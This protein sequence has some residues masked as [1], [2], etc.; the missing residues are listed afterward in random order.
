VEVG[1]RAVEDAGA[2]L[3]F[4]GEADVRV[5]KRK[6]VRVLRGAELGAAKDGPAGAS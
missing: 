4:E 6:F 2:R 3:V 1:G 5:R